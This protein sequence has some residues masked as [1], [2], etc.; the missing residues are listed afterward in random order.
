MYQTVLIA[1]LIVLSGCGK[2]STPTQLKQP[3]IKETTGGSY[4]TEQSS[5]SVQIEPFNITYKFSDSTTGKISQSMLLSLLIAKQ[6]WE[7]IIVE[8]LPDV[9]DTLFGNG[10]IDDLLARLIHEL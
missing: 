4:Q 2:V 1:L 8:G 7:R 5:P 3:E 6:R 10:E 9:Y